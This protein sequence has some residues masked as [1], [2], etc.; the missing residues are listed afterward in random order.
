MA[1]EQS[2]RALVV[3]LGPASLGLAGDLVEA[4][5]T[6]LRLNASH[7]TTA[8]V[9]AAVDGL[10]REGHTTPIVVDLQGAKM[11]LGRF[12]ERAIVAGDRVSLACDQGPADALPVPHAELFE[13]VR[14]GETLSVDDDRLRFEVVDVS[15]RRLDLRALTGGILRARK[16]VNVVEHPVVLEDLAMADLGVVD[17]LRGT[18]GVAWA[19]SF[20]ADGREAEWV[21]H[22]IPAGRVI[23]KIE[24]RE[25]IRNVGA[26]AAATDEIWVC[27]GDLGAQVGAQ[28]LARFV[29][30]FDPRSLVRPVLMAGQ[31]L[32]HLTAHSEPTRS[33][34]CH[35][36]DL[37]A[38]GYVGIVLS[39][40][41]AIGHD[42]VRAARIAAEL[43]RRLGS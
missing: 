16:G 13:Q 34:V 35:L 29:G 18:A 23:G 39:D 4:G 32:E 2:G 12:V 20:M 43:L 42:P 11:R 25:A 37:L 22:R 19:V 15:E 6:A 5:A 8:E 36:H 10:R 38:R 31:V 28:E 1:L 30:G 26:I 9:R 40:E 41:T 7:M 21:R 17:A 14:P 24:R 33:E 3:T 27:R